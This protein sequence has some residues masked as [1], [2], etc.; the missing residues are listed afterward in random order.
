MIRRIRRSTPPAE[1]VVVGIGD[2]CAVLEPTAGQHLLAT[3]DLLLEDIHFRRCYAEPADIGWKSMAVNL[4]DIAA[5]GGR[6][7][8]ALVAL[9]L[10]VDTTTPSGEM[11]AHVLAV[12]A[13]FERRL[14][15]QR[16]RDA[17]AVRRTQGVRLGRPTALSP[18][19]AGRIR[20]MSGKGESL[21]E[22]ARALNAGAVPTAHGGRRWYPSTVRAVLGKYD[23][24]RSR[25]G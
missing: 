6:P 21:S 5:M 19:T 25:A 4:S 15:G 17:L 22:I 16:T 8:W 1:G 7:R 10:G 18:R 14:I 24:R 2:D 20:A 12:F 3:T 13:Q 9:D 23:S 11:L